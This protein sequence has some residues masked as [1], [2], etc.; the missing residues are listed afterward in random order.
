MN[1]NK[2]GVLFLLC[3]E[4]DHSEVDIP[5]AAHQPILGNGEIPLGAD[6][7]CPHR[8]RGH[9]VRKNITVFNKIRNSVSSK[10]ESNKSLISIKMVN[11]TVVVKKIKCLSEPSYWIL[12]LM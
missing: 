4:G 8:L 10:Y 11:V 9:Q 7:P 12:I 3:A 2:N 1:V 5:Q 6:R